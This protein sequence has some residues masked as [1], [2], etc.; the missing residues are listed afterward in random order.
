M[1]SSWGE[2]GRGVHRH[3]YKVQMSRQGTFIKNVDKHLEHAHI[4]LS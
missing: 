2:E 1:K 3:R 4:R